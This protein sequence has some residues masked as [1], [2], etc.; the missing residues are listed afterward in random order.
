[1]SEAKNSNLAP[2]RLLVKLTNGVGDE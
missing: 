1:M 2:F